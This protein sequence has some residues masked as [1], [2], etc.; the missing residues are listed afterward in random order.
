MTSSSASAQSRRRLVSETLAVPA[1]QHYGTGLG[2]FPPSQHGVCL[3]R[4]PWVALKNA[5]GVRGGEDEWFEME[6]VFENMEHVARARRAGACNGK[7]ASRGSRPRAQ[8]RRPPVCAIQTT[9]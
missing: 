6:A 8:S 7:S 2:A 4:K 5:T 1:H 3:G 9:T